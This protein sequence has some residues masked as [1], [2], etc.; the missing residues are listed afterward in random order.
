MFRLPFLPLVSAALIANVYAA[1]PD[2]V[3]P[4]FNRD[5]MPINH[6]GTLPAVPSRGRDRSHAADH[7]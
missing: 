2:A 5:V 1:A 6:A 3:L 4:T 7:L